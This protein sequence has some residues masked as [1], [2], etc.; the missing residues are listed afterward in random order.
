MSAITRIAQRKKKLILRFMSNIIFDVR[1][2]DQK[3]GDHPNFR[4]TL[5]ELSGSFEVFSEKLSDFEIPFSEWHP[6]TWATRKPQFSEQLPEPFPELM[7]TYLKD[8]HLPQHSRRFFSRIG[9]SPRARFETKSKTNKTNVCWKC[10][11]F[12]DVMYL[13]HDDL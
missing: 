1:F 7:G 9:W 4:Q 13:C 12:A 2:F 8:F 3:P 10:I 6:T 5:A 11:I